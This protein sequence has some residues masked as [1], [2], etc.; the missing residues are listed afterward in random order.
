MNN[1]PKKKIRIICF[2][3]ICAATMY[4]TP[5]S[6]ASD[7]G[8]ADT[9]A[10]ESAES[11]AAGGGDSPSAARV[12]ARAPRTVR[13]SLADAAA[14]AEKMYYC[15]ELYIFTDSMIKINFELASIAGTVR[16]SVKSGSIFKNKAV[17]N[18]LNKKYNAICATYNSWVDVKGDLEYFIETIG[19]RNAITKSQL[20]TAFSR[21]LKTI[22]DTRELLG[23]AS[24]C[25]EDNASAE[26]RA[27]SG[28]ADA[29]TATAASAVAVIAPL[30]QTALKGYRALF[31]QF[32]IQAGLEPEYKTWS[33]PDDESDLASGS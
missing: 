4:A 2:V 28:S 15:G 3:L 21:T 10:V 9:L 23:K 25:Y 5:V 12:S 31:D 1:I 7:A 22:G 27:L 16:E 8:G 18:S 32:T 13:V 30:A 19:A 6:Y 17:I 20:Q 29:L 24:D 14:T 11:P 33:V 26:R